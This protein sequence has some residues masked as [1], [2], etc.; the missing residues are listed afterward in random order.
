MKLER[1][2]E[3][4]MK[5]AGVLCREGGGEQ[6]AMDVEK[7]YESIGGAGHGGRNGT[8]GGEKRRRGLGGWVAG[9]HNSS[10]PLSSMLV[11]CSWAHLSTS[12]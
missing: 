9:E 8:G 5:L 3:L 4:D 1:M 11:T 12:G 7:G 6:G 10:V 2:E